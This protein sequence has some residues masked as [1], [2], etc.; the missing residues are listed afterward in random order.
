[1][2]SVHTFIYFP[3]ALQVSISIS[4]LN[5]WSSKV[6]SLYLAHKSVWVSEPTCS[7]ITGTGGL[8]KASTKNYFVSD[9]ALCKIQFEELLAPGFLFDS[10]KLM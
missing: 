3:E 2:Y 10:S 4:A 6:L 8:H 7:R 1:M 9:T 5:G